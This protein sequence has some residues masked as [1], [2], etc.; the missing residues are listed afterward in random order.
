M[1]ARLVGDLDLPWG[2]GVRE[3]SID[4]LGVQACMLLGAYASADV[5]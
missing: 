5:N 2:C 1:Q 4:S 3:P